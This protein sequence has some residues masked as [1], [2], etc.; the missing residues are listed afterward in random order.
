MM[1]QVL[2]P[3]TLYTAARLAAEP[4]GGRPAEI[5]D[6]ELI[7]MSPCGGFHSEIASYL[8]GVLF[9]FTRTHRDLKVLGDNT[10]FLVSRDPDTLLSPDVSLFRR[11]GGK[12]GPWIAFSPELVI[13]VLSPSNARR[14]MAYKK[15]KYF[16]GGTEQL[17]IVD[18]D[19]KA[20]EF[21]FRDGRILEATGGKVPGEGIVEGFLLDLDELWNECDFEDGE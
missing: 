16:V 9:E 4:D 10:D 7:E 20:V 1:P 5:W 12:K 19:R 17:W 14:E 15:L 21:H 6:G 3:K 18:A 2:H 13:E 11:R 8:A